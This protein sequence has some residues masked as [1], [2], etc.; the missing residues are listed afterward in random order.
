MAERCDE[1]SLFCGESVRALADAGFMGL[2]YPPKL[3]GRGSSYESYVRCVE[4]LSKVCPS[5]G[6]TYATHV[7]LACH[8]L[9]AFGSPMQKESFLRPMLRG[10]KLGAFA[11]TEPEAGS[12][13]GAIA[14]TAELDGGFY[15]INGHKI[16][17]TNAGRADIYILFARTGGQGTEGL[18]AFVV[19]SDDAGL[20]ISAPQRKMGIRGAQT[21][22]LFL[23]NLCIPADCLI[24]R[25]GDGFRIAMETLDGGRLGI[26]AQAVGI[27][28]AAFD[29]ARARLK[30]RRQF[31]RALEHFQ[32]LRWKAADMWAKVEAARQ[33]TLYAA[34]L[35]D[36]GKRFRA[37]AS[38]AKL[39]ASEAAVWCAS[40]AVQ[41]CGGSGYLQGSVAERLYRDAKITQ[42][43]EGTSEV[44]R[45]VIAS[46]VLG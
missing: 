14:T 29:E 23:R 15:V 4:R 39:V 27:A 22:E 18:S 2:P 9:H 7:G 19:C 10:D 5:V 35:R 26:A 31:G 3:G 32:G 43:Y 30:E 38:A 1:E 24:G 34:R 40:E 42:I 16:F 46:G 45:M 37:E 33:L 17:I 21:C 36:G 11:L 41:I 20:L 13:V 12:D 28:D 25:P 44:Q 6:V 8:P